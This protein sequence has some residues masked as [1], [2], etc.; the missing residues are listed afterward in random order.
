M[1][2]CQ[3]CDTQIDESSSFC[4]QCGARVETGSFG[5]PSQ[6]FGESLGD[7]PQNSRDLFGDRSQSFGDPSRSFAEQ[8]Q[9]DNVQSGNAQSGNA[10]SDNV[11]SGNAQSG[12]AQSGNVQSDNAQSGSVNSQYTE[13]QSYPRATIQHHEAQNSTMQHHDTTNVQQSAMQNNQHAQY[14]RQFEPYAEQQ[15]MYQQYQAN[16]GQQQDTQQILP[17]HA[18]YKNLG[19]WLLFFMLAAVFGIFVNLVVSIR[20]INPIVMIWDFIHLFPEELSRAL[21]IELISGIVML[22]IV[23]LQ[24][25][26]VVCILSRNPMFLKIEQIS[27]IILCLSQ[28]ALVVS[29]NMARMLPSPGDA[30]TIEL[31][32]RPFAAIIGMIIMTAY[33]SRSVRVRVYMRSDDFKKRALFSFRRSPHWPY[34]DV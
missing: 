21:T 18:K 22:S 32:A 10:Q 8:A 3:T 15:R 12:N 26:F 23:I 29:V 13:T 7:R 14:Q 1:K 30:G 27:Y 9:S 17:E 6:S 11:Q 33:Y 31:F 4:R 2:Y 19:G 5:D 20:I 28:I 25:A 24:I 16:Y 34:L